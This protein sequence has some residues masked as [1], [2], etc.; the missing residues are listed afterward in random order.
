HH[1]FTSANTSVPAGPIATSGGPRS[2]KSIGTLLLV[3]VVG[4]A[5]IFASS[6]L[7]VIIHTVTFIAAV[8]G[9]PL[10]I[11]VGLVRLVYKFGLR[12]LGRSVALNVAA[13]EFGMCIGGAV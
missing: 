4:A 13:K 2:L 12:L 10:L 9:G 5:V 3:L 1:S 8:V 11:L 7:P 6:Y